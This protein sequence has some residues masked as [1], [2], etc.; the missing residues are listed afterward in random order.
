L[1]VS[2]FGRLLT[3]TGADAPPA[4]LSLPP[5]PP[6]GELR[7]DTEL[8]PALH[9]GLAERRGRRRVLGRPCQD[10]RTAGPP[11]AG[12]L[13]RIA[14][15][16]DSDFT[17]T[18]LDTHG[19]V[20]EEIG[21]SRGQTV[22]RKVAVDL[23][24]NPSLP[25]ELFDTTGPVAPVHEGGGS[26]R[27]VSPTSRPPGQFWE[28]GHPLQGF[29]LQGRFAVIPPQPQ[30]FSDPTRFANRQAGVVDVYRR[31]YDVLLIERGG[32]LG[33]AA[34][35]TAQPDEAT[36]DLSALGQ[37]QLLIGLATSEARVSLPGGHY[38]RV[39]GTVSADFLIQVARD[40]QAVAGNDLVY[41]DKPQP[42]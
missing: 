31:G 2:S 25:N 42:G 20:L 26:V 41:L 16:K 34:P 19:L 21:V 28:L 36:V 11:E 4:I 1:T 39:A 14:T 18:C 3:K 27:P 17:D 29:D 8:Q 10:Y 33:G 38:V 13:H 24:F 15:S 32:T 22:Y 7:S 23:Q 35:F 40:L 6:P 5:A 9:D 30:N 37:G 12:S